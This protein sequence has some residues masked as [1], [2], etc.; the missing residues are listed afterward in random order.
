[1]VQVNVPLAKHL[2]WRSHRQ[3][4]IDAQ[5]VGQTGLTTGGVGTDEVIDAGGCE[6]QESAGGANSEI[7]GRGRSWMGGRKSLGK[8]AQR[9][10][11]VWEGANV[12]QLAP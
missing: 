12:D 2:H 9:S 10:R 1:M 6:G 5:V 4:R 7:C 11:S 3:V 8:S